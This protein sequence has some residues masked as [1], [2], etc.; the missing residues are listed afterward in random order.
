ML[1]E[2]LGNVGGYP[3]R[4]VPDVLGGVG[5]V[6]CVRHYCWGY[7]YV[8]RYSDKLELGGWLRIEKAFENGNRP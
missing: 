8:P 6:G 5:R 3:A 7:W 2:L 4:C 1:E